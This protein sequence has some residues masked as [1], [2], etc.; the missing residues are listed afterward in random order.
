VQVKCSCLSRRDLEQEDACAYF[1]K[2]FKVSGL[3][4]MD[5]AAHS[6]SHW[7]IWM[8]AYANVFVWLQLSACIVLYD[9]KMRCYIS[10]AGMVGRHRPNYSM[11]F[12]AKLRLY[13]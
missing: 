4:Y 7:Y 11:S 12:L 6:S 9:A 2:G 10:S 3:P 1:K 8:N 13:L 5:K